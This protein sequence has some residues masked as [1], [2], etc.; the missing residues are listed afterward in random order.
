MCQRYGTGLEIRS[1]GLALWSRWVAGGSGCTGG[2][3]R[4]DPRVELSAWHV[5]GEARWGRA[6]R[7]WRGHNRD[8]DRIALR[9]HDV[10]CRNRG[11]GCRG[12]GAHVTCPP[13]HTG[14]ARQV[15]APLRLEVVAKLLGHANVTT[16]AATYG[17]LSVED[18]RKVLQQAGWVTGQGRRAFDRPARR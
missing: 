16:T 6:G 10:H 1:Q 18:A 3:S 2:T 5:G 12:T 15:R 7:S 4:I 11:G 9:L 14:I 8:D 17:H 13:R